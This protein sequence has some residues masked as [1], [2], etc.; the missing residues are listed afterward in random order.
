M[1]SPGW[2]LNT[3]YT[4]SMKINDWIHFFERMADTV[5]KG[6][7]DIPTMFLTICVRPECRTITGY[8]GKCCSKNQSNS[9]DVICIFNL[10]NRTENIVRKGRKIDVTSIFFFFSR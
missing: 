9:R 2:S 4:V 8:F 10:F 3:G 6:E 7:K 5:R 1:T